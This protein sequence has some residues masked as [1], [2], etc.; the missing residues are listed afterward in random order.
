MAILYWINQGRLGNLLFQYAAIRA[1]TT[2]DDV[3]VCFDNELFDLIDT[4][5]R[6]IRLPVV[7]P[8]SLGHRINMYA[9]LLAE[10][11]SSRRAIGRIAPRMAVALDHFEI[12]TEAVD[13]T[14]GWLKSALAISGYFQH[15]RW[16]HPYPRLHESVLREAQRLLDRIAPI[17]PTVAI[18]IRLGD[19]RQ[20]SVFGNQGVDLPLEFFTRAIRLAK[21]RLV[22][23]HFVVFTDSHISMRGLDLGV[24]HSLFTSS[25]A[26]IDFAAMTLCD[27]AIISPSSFSWWAAYLRGNRNGFV[28]AP[29]FWAGFKARTWFPATIQTSRFEYLD[30]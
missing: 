8:R 30:V 21:E 4:E 29:K 15:D 24:E 20:W 25:S 5:R 23:P 9:N 17:S 3:V 7:R 18:H 10:K 16:I 19:Y 28:L 27:H 1:H 12:E 22:S 26:H 13:R 14:E 6:F 2:K 11:L